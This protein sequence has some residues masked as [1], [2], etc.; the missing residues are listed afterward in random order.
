MRR[1]WYVSTEITITRE[2]SPQEV[3]K[4]SE[5]EGA[6]HLFDDDGLKE[7]DSTEQ[8]VRLTFY[9]V[10]PEIS[11]TEWQQNKNDSPI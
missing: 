8:P 5:S 9:T 11:T 6:T 1:H 7:I 10:T 4:W 3:E 2:E